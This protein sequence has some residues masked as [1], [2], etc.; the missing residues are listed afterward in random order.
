MQNATLYVYLHLIDWLAH[1]NHFFV[2]VLDNRLTNKRCSSPDIDDIARSPSPK[3][4]SVS[5][6]EVHVKQE[7][8]SKDDDEE[9][10]RQ[11]PHTSGSPVSSRENPHETKHDH[12]QDQAHEGERIING[13]RSN[14]RLEP[15]SDIST[16]RQKSIELLMKIFPTHSSRTLELLLQ[17]CR[18]NV[19]EAIEC[20][21]ASQR[22]CCPPS[23]VKYTGL[24]A[25]PIDSCTVPTMA[26]SSPFLHNSALAREQVGV[27]F[28]NVHSCTTSRIYQPLPLP[29][30]LIIKPKAGTPHF[31]IP[32]PQRAIPTIP[33]T[34][35]PTSC[36]TSKFCTYC[37]N[38][39]M[40][41]DQFCSSCGTNVA[42][43]PS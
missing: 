4:K 33:T 29:P 20:V 8:P 2:F 5:P 30:P 36:G 22:S 16:T 38:K 7:H 3:R 21:L 14:I 41:F 11:S 39:M 28:T 10:C 26:H 27:P 18:E 35:S 1:W 24:R 37:G 25:G 42:L 15:H 40:M 34:I 43:S 19:V 9:T 6:S 31:K 32:T 23:G 12:Y 17:S 13:I